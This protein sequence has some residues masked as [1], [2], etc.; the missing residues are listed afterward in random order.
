MHSLIW[1]FFLRFCQHEIKHSN[2]IQT[3]PHMHL[4][5]RLY[6]Q[7]RQT[8]GEHYSSHKSEFTCVPHIWF[9]WKE[10]VENAM[11]QIFETFLILCARLLVFLLMV[12]T[13]WMLLTYMGV[14]IN[15]FYQKMITVE[16]P[17]LMQVNAAFEAH[18]RHLLQIL[19][20]NVTFSA[21]KTAT[22][23][24]NSWI[25]KAFERTRSKSGFTDRNREIK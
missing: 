12:K 4:L 25:L 6:H 16:E 20:M 7:I 22:R 9:N 24:N 19:L 3:K 15:E 18:S 8:L 13:L 10:H 17:T 2:P 14:E 1:F 11:E 21:K 5:G 23:R